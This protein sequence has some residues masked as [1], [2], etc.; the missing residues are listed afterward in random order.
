MTGWRVFDPWPSP[1]RE[2]LEQLMNEPRPR[3]SGPVPMP[4]NVY[5]DGDALVVEASLP[6]VRPEDVELSCVDGVLTIRARS[7]VAEREYL[8]QEI[9]AVEYL[10]RISLPPDCRFDQAQADEEHGL[11]VIRVPK[12]RP[13]APETIRIQITRKKPE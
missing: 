12:I 10:R 6:G 4:M 2:A 11:V 3:A 7:T 5:E 13:K 8:H 1:M 9:R